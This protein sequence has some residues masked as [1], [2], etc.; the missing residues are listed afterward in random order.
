VSFDVDKVV[1]AVKEA[2]KLYNRLAVLVGPSGSGKSALLH[3][4]AGKTS[5]KVVNV[6]LELS[7]KML[8]RTVK[9][10]K[11]KMNEIF[12]EVTGSA[13]PGPV[14]LDNIEI[15][16]DPSF[17]QDPLRLLKSVARNRTVLVAWNGHVE[18]GVLTYADHS[19]P[20]FYRAPI[21]DFVVL[22]QAG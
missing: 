16:F 18:K 15:L 19:H 11:L 9:Q 14:L 7:R 20:E 5:N 1:A 6:N 2:D 21:E 17:A 22:T 8:E 4:I 13:K 12:A 3:E 10:R